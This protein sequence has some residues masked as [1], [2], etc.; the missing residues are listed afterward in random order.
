[1]L[2]TRVFCL[3]GVPVSAPNSDTAAPDEA[4]NTPGGPT[5]TT[6]VEQA[7]RCEHDG[8]LYASPRCKYVHTP[9]TVTT[10]TTVEISDRLR[11]AG[12]SGD[13]DR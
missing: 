6:R 5:V 10:T 3:E 11:G 9:V 13:T 7:W 1:M 12:S 8:Q 2:S 4:D